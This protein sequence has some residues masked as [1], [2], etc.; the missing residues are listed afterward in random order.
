MNNKKKKELVFFYVGII[1]CVIFILL[2]EVYDKTIPKKFNNAELQ[3]F[4]SSENVVCEIEKMRIGRNTISINGWCIEKNVPIRTYAIELLL[5]DGKG[6]IYIIPTQMVGKRDKESL[7]DAK[8]ARV[9]SGGFSA[10]FFKFSLNEGMYS[11][12]VLCKNN[13]KKYLILTDKLIGV[14]KK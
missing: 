9:T 2:F 13:N 1:L 4:I 7:Y 11:V 10:R 5:D 12:K 14:I 8:R 3:N 6:N